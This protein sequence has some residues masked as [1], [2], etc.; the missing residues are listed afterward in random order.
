M[1]LFGNLRVTIPHSLVHPCFLLTHSRE[2]DVKEIHAHLHATNCQLVAVDPQGWWLT[3]PA[4][5]RLPLPQPDAPQW[6]QVK[7]DR[8]QVAS[9]N[10]GTMH[11][12]K[13]SRL[14]MR[15]AG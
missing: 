2:L 11:R 13:V 3:T 1:R 9:T 6:C 12:P 10:G 14:E 15:T 4:L 7:I 5:P 8:L